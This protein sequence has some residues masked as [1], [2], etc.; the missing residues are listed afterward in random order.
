MHTASAGE[1]LLYLVTASCF[2]LGIRFLGSPK[3]ARR[4][5]QVA[6]FGM[7]VGLVTTGIVE[8]GI[9]WAYV[10]PTIAV[11]TVVGAVSARA[12]RMTAMPQ[13]VA[14]F[15]GMGAGAAALIGIAD[16]RDSGGA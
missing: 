5:N 9:S 16:Y 10:A 6:A 11:G 8:T 4:G 3:T 13:M 1:I 2:I 12:V 7:L 14:M 15:N